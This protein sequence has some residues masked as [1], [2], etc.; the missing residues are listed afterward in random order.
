MVL[1]R[2]I[3]ILILTGTIGYRFLLDIPLVDALYMTPEA[4]L[5]SMFIIIMSIGTVGY[6]V[7]NIVSLFVEG[8]IKEAWKLKRMENTI[9]KLENHYIICG[10]GDVVL[11]LEDVNIREGSSLCNLTLKDSAIPEKT[12]LIVLALR[13]KEEKNMFFNPGPNERLHAGDAMVV[14]GRDDQVKKLREIAHDTEG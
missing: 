3:F 2:L 4:K 10:A 9:S 1:V 12:G 14:L 13:R 11:S 6:V 5:F 7:S 8:E